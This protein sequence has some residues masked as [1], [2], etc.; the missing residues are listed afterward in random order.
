M[1][2]IK[3]QAKNIFVNVLIL[4]S[5]CIVSTTAYSTVPNSKPIELSQTQTAIV[6]AALGPN[7]YLTD[8]M[9]DAFWAD[10]SITTQNKY[11]GKFSY[12]KF[13]QEDLLRR[14]NLIN[15]MWRSALLSWKKGEDIETKAFINAVKIHQEL[16][17]QSNRLAKLGAR[18]DI[19]AMMQL[20]LM[21]SSS[22]K[23]EREGKTPVI[24][25]E[26][27]EL[28]LAG[29]LGSKSRAEAL[30]KPDWIS[31]SKELKFDNF[32]ISIKFTW[33]PNV[34]Y[35]IDSKSHEKLSL[36][37]IIKISQTVNNYYSFEIERY[38]SRDKDISLE[39]FLKLLAIKRQLR[40][41]NISITHKFQNYDS[42]TFMGIDE[43]G[44]Y[45]TIA[46][47]AID[48]KEPSGIIV[49]FVKTVKE[50]AYKVEDYREKIEELISINY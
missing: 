30:A 47:R 5:A 10:V 13:L 20:I 48:L 24:K 12:T 21:A 26:D 23:M 16:A 17:S 31:T 37:P 25:L 6:G 11:G 42:A 41:K 27:I 1:N 36:I 39:E 34:Q 28:G 43:V 40:I 19:A 18:Q 22:G 33:P 46:A 50:K 32:P 15:E 7:G 9:Y 29:Y 44:K 14:V 49:I 45:T 38:I 4:I 8:R 3:F 2:L 35:F